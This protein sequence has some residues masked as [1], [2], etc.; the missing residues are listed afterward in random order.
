MLWEVALFG[1]KDNC[2]PGGKYANGSLQPGRWLKSHLQAD[3]L[4]TGISSMPNN[5]I[6]KTWC[7]KVNAVYRLIV[8]IPWVFSGNFSPLI[9]RSSKYQ[10]LS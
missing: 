10:L 2:R 5:V 7:Q 3:C 6:C 9:S 1:W 8:G 4:Y